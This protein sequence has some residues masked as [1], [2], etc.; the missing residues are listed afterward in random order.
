M[1]KK[2]QKKM[3]KDTYYV[4][5]GICAVLIIAVLIFYADE[6]EGE[7]ISKPQRYTGEEVEMGEC[8]D[9]DGQN[10]FVKGKVFLDGN[11]YGEDYCKDNF[12]WEYYCGL[13][14]MPDGEFY[15]KP[16][17]RKVTCGFGCEDGACFK[18]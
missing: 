15:T 7:A 11:E 8:I 5:L 4:V 18:R 13:E 1:R 17:Q 3:S 16:K 10:Q 6:T 2:K 9:E 14:K 12:V